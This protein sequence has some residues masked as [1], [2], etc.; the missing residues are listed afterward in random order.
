[1]AK[2]KHT[3]V[4]YPKGKHPPKSKADIIAEAKAEANRHKE[5]ITELLKK[6]TPIKIPSNIK[7]LPKTK[8]KATLK[9]SLTKKKDKKVTFLRSH[10]PMLD[11]IAN[12]RKGYKILLEDPTTNVVKIF[13]NCARNLLKGNTKLSSA[14]MHRLAHDKESIRELAGPSSITK[15][16]KI[17]Q[18][19]GF[20]PLLAAGALGA[21]AP[22]LLGGL[23][24]QR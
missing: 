18:K 24:G 12:K 13:C 20:L 17:I 10:L 1:M 6:I 19:G 16:K 5:H 11:T 22:N 8:T 15:K 23:F 9:S 7:P 21:L 14:Q 2:T 4:K 3:T